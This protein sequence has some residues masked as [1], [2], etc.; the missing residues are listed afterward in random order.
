MSV[1]SIGNEDISSVKKNILEMVFSKMSDGSKLR[2]GHGCREVFFFGYKSR[3]NFAAKNKMANYFLFLQ[4]VTSEVFQSQ[5]MKT[6][7]LHFQFLPFW[8]WS[9]L[10]FE[11]LKDNWIWADVI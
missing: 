8:L 5:V 2:S 4:N 3:H 7:Y 1:E 11:E 6:T 10:Y 9:T